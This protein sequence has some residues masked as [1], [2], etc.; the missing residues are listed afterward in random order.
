[1][2]GAGMLHE[3]N[4]AAMKRGAIEELVSPGRGAY[5]S[6]HLE[7]KFKTLSQGILPHGARI[8]YKS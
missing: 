8:P 5:G 1:M 3:D 7:D 6:V 4:V 2:L